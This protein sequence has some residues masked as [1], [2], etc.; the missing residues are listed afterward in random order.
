MR[1]VCFTGFF[2]LADFHHQVKKLVFEFLRV[3]NFK[4]AVAV[5]DDAVC[6]PAVQRLLYQVTVSCQLHDVAVIRLGGGCAALYLNRDEQPFLLHQVIR[7]TGNPQ[8]G[9]K[10][11]AFDQ[12]LAPAAVIIH[13][14]PQGKSAL[15]LLAVCLPEE[16]NCGKCQDTR[17]DKKPGHIFD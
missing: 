5:A 3:I 11:G 17:E 8:G 1:P 2:Y 9:F 10:E 15:C 12:A 6:W 13:N 4:T 14:S 7:F 16:K